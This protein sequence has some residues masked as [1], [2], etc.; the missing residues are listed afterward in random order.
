MFFL[1]KKN[2]LGARFCAAVT[3]RGQAAITAVIFL[4][5]VLLSILAALSNLALKEAKNAERNFRGRTAFYSAESGVEDAVYRLKRGKNIVN[6][7]SISLSGSFA[8]TTINDI[9]GGKEVKSTGEF[10][11]NFRSLRSILLSGAGAD[12]FYGMQVG[13]GGISMNNG[14]LINGNVFS[15]GVITGSNGAKILGDAVAVGQIKDMIIGSSTAGIARAPSFLNTVVHG[16]LCPNSYCI[17]ES[18]ASENFPIATSTIQVW[19][20]DAEVGGIVSGDVVVNSSLSIGPRKIT[21]KLTVTNGSILT[22]TGTLWV[23]GDIVFD[24]NSIIK[25]DS[26]YDSFS[27]VIVG[28]AKI[29]IKNGAVFSGSGSPSSFLALIAAKDSVSEE[30]INVDNNSLGVIYYASGGKI[31]FSNNAE[32]KEAT[33]YGIILDNNAIITYDSGLQNVNFSSGP[34]GGWSINEWKEIIQ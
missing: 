2:F 29:D 33:A 21:G 30:L 25:L 1:N 15:N 11:Q 28:D 26:S 13:A 20:N 5:L 4:L 31:K 19:K 18:P 8:S 32:A 17:V 10:L 6:L 3:R 14:S 27:G 23:L 12:F 7:F 24:N 34:F 9:F 16:S 22:I